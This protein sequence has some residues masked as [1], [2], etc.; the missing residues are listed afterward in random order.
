VERIV[1]EHGGTITVGTSPSG[2]AQF[3]IFLPIET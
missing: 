3:Q 2:G 1:S